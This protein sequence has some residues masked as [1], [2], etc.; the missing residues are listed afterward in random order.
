MSRWIASTAMVAYSTMASMMPGSYQT[1]YNAS[2]SF[3]QSFVKALQAAR[4]RAEELG[5]G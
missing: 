4:T 5:R 2:K 1:V 3:V